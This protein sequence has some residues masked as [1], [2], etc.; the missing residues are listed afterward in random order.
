VHPVLSTAENREDDHLCRESAEQF[1]QEQ[2][3]TSNVES[4]LAQLEATIARFSTP[5]IPNVINNT[6]NHITNNTNNNIVVNQFGKEDL[7]HLSSLDLDRMVYRTKL[8]L[9]QLTEYIHFKKKQNKNVRVTDLNMD[10]MEYHNG[11]RWIYG[12]KDDIMN[13]VIGNGVELMTDHFDSE[14]LR[15]STQWSTTMFEHVKGWLEGMYNKSDD[16]YAPALRDVY[17]MIC[18]N[19]NTPRLMVKKRRRNSL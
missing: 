18:N 9:I 10:M 1:V 13:K 6:T 8:G 5:T 7:S 12:W 16:V 17:M 4:R 2:Q 14:H 19:T 15:L 11:A 3:S